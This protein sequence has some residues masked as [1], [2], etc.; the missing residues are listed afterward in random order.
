M[1]LKRTSDLH[2]ADLAEVINELNPKEATYLVKLFPSE[3]TADV[4]TELDEDL[5]EQILAKLTWEEIAAEIAELD[6]DDAVDIITEFDEE[7]A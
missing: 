4:F 2:Y 1:L 3:K 5:R 6:T 7:I